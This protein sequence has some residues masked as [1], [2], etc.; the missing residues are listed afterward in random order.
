MSR[1]SAD[2]FEEII[3]KCQETINR[4]KLMMEN[5]RKKLIFITMKKMSYGKSQNLTYEGNPPKFAELR[6]AKNIV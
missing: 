6:L 5:R 3:L 1:F 4:K 2:G